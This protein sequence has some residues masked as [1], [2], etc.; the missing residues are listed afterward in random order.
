M[1]ASVASRLAAVRKYDSGKEVFNLIMLIFA[2]NKGV[3]TKIQKTMGILKKEETVN[4]ILKEKISGRRESHHLQPKYAS[5][6]VLYDAGAQAE[7]DIHGEEMKRH[8]A[9]EDEIMRAEKERLKEKATKPRKH[10]EAREN[11]QATKDVRE[12]ER[13]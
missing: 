10:M 9:V 5:E 1:K 12:I 7:W 4:R 8:K 6:R 13:D 11:A 3:S 2:S